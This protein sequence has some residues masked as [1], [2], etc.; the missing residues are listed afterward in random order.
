[1]SSSNDP[2]G[3]ALMLATAGAA[4]ACVGEL[5]WLR[6]A[7]RL[8]VT[9]AQFGMLFVPWLTAA[10]TNL[11]LWYWTLK[12]QRRTPLNVLGLKA[13]Y[14]VSAAFAG[15]FAWIYGSFVFELF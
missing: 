11:L 8:E 7:H 10:V 2:I 4:L 6:S 5:W 15:A 9:H 13:V 1:M 14:V 12:R 3:R